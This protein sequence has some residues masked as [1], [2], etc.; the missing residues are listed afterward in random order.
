MR[1]SD[2][3]SDVCSSDLAGF[4]LHAVRAAVLVLNDDHGQPLPLGS[5]VYLGDATVPLMV[6]YDGQV[7]LEGLASHNRLHIDLG[8]GDDCALDFEFDERGG[9][10]PTLGTYTCHG[11]PRTAI[12]SEKHTHE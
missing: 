3:S 6:G 2:W 12:R 8:N 5:R 9:S 11:T 1:I 4:E 7:Y 10:I